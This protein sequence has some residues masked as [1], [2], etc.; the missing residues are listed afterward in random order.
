[1]AVSPRRGMFILFY[2]FFVV[3]SRGLIFAQ[4]PGAQDIH[5]FL[6]KVAEKIKSYPEYKNWKA[7]AALTITKMDKNWRPE[8]VTVVTKNVKVTNGKREEEILKAVETKKGKTKD[9]T[10]KYAEE[11]GENREKEKNRR[12][13]E[14]NEKNKDDESRGGSLSLDSLLPFSEKKRD[15]FDFRLSEGAA[16]NGKPAVVLDFVAKVKDEKNWEGRFYFD[17]ATYDLLQLEV[18]PSANPRMVKELEVGMTFDILQGRYLV[19]KSSHVKINGGIFIK[20][21]RQVVEEEY[22]GFE[23]LDDNH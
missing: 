6:D 14:E 17:P 18:K 19:L 2:A 3:S 9:V 7:S 15:Q 11:A 20:H 22:S 16:L 10:L 12:A 21:I 4:I 23:V 5:P 13:E 1:M 8:S